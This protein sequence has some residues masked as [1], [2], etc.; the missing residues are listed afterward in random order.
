MASLESYVSIVERFYKKYSTLLG[1]IL[2][3][4]ITAILDWVKD[5]PVRMKTT[6]P[7][8]DRMFFLKRGVNLLGTL[9]K[10]YQKE[11]DII[12]QQILQ[13]QFES[14]KT[15]TCTAKTLN[16]L[17]QL[18]SDYSTF[19]ED[20]MGCLDKSST[21]MLSIFKIAYRHFDGGYQRQIDL[22]ENDCM[23]IR[24]HLLRN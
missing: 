8:Q 15:G 18:N 4:N 17:K 7:A 11:R 9:V 20:M 6:I 23:N 22:L 13:C 16:S 21:M 2:K 1:P 3:Q 24:L 10:Q 12:E 19:I 5:Y 14:L